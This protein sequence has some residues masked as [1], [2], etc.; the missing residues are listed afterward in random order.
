MKILHTADIHLKESDDERWQALSEI[1]ELGNRELIDALI[2]SGDLFDKD[3]DAMKLKTSIRELFSRN[4][5]RI[6]IIPGNHDSNSFEEGSF[7]GANVEIIN[8]NDDIYEIDGVSIAGLPYMEIRES[9]I[10]ER[11]NNISGKLSKDK[12]N[13]LL[14]HGELLNTFYSRGDFGEEGDSRY[15]PVTLDYFNEMNFDYIL[16]GHFHTNF[17]VWEFDKKRY[18]P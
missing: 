17:N 16:A 9:E 15:M 8:T 1:I 5:Y 3:I 7:L 18:F 13:I 6:F 12:C 11:L 4:N 2:I 14:Y 10:F